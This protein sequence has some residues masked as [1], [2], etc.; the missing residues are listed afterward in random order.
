MYLSILASSTSQPSLLPAPRMC[1]QHLQECLLF[2]VGLQ[3][4]LEV[5][6]LWQHQTGHGIHSFFSSCSRYCIPMDSKACCWRFHSHLPRHP[7]DRAHKVNLVE[8]NMLIDLQDQNIQQSNIPCM[9]CKALFPTPLPRL[10][11]ELLSGCLTRQWVSLS[12]FCLAG[13]GNAWQLRTP[14]RHDFKDFLGLF[15]D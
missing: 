14:C 6:C 7:L 8:W 2:V 11:W 9:P 10:Y 12:R 3:Q 13:T 4:L 15:V 5:W 1:S